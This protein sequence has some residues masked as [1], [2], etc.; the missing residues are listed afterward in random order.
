LA[1]ADDARGLSILQIFLGHF[2]KLSA[3]FAISLLAK[4]LATYRK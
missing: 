4:K 2:E 1:C 3:G